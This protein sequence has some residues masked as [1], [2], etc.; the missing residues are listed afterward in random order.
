MTDVPARSA[1]NVRTS[2]R[3]RLPDCPTAGRARTRT[4]GPRPAALDAEG[5]GAR[6]TKRRP[7][8]APASA[9]FQGKNHG[10]SGDRHGATRFFDALTRPIDGRRDRP[11]RARGFR[12]RLLPR[13]TG[14]PGPIVPGRGPSQRNG[15]GRRLPP[16]RQPS[17]EPAP[18]RGLVSAPARDRRRPDRRPA[19]RTE[20]PAHRLDRALVPAG[21]GSRRPLPAPVGI[22]IALSSTVDGAGPRSAAARRRRTGGGEGSRALR[23]Q[24]PDGVPGHHGVGLQDA[25][26]PRLR[27]D[28]DLRPMGDRCR[29]SRPRT[30][31]NVES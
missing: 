28:P 3:V 13:G 10:C 25:D 23:C 8:V 6:R 7:E 1:S 26:V 11:G 9:D 4:V 16:S 5:V 17:G 24:R 27:S 22:V 19:V 2:E 30:G 20:P 21:A 31:T 18:G 15:R 29:P 12:R 14:H